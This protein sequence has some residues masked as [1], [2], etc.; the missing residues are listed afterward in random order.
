VHAGNP[1][2]KG[3]IRRN[4]METKQTDTKE[5]KLEQQNAEHF[6]IFGEQS[7]IRDADGC[8]PCL[9]IVEESGLFVG[10]PPLERRV[11]TVVPFADEEFGKQYTARLNR[12]GGLGFYLHHA[13][14]Q[15]TSK[16][17]KWTD[18]DLIAVGLEPLE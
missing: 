15:V 4:Y 10:I 7:A 14:I 8:I 11:H 16:G 17:K 6:G 9:V 5:V 13:R 1:I 3:L 12:N 18:E 2:H